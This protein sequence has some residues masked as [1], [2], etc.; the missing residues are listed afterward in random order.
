MHSALDLASH[1]FLC[2]IVVGS[3]GMGSLLDRSASVL[4]ELA[5]C[6]IAESARAWRENMWAALVD[7]V[8]ASIG[9]LD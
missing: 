8:R 6:A 1:C 2:R 4:G 7:L 3:S 9:D 5:L